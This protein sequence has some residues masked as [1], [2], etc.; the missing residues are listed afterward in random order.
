MSWLFHNLLAVSIGIGSVF[1]MTANWII[2][3]R[4]KRRHVKCSYVLPLFAGLLGCM[5]IYLLRIEIDH[6]YLLLP[7]V[8]AADIGWLFI[9]SGL[10]WKR[11]T[12]RKKS[13][14]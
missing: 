14:G 7:F 11:T 13:T 1:L 6:W 2:Y 3:V 12:T 4:Q 8:L 10:V 9:F 5:A